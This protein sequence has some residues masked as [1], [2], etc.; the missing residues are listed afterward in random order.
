M[1]SGAKPG[2]RRGGRHAGVPN[3][4][5]T[6]ALERERIEQQLAAPVSAET[7]AK[8]EVL[9]PPGTP[10]E[11]VA[12]RKLAKERLEDLLELFVGAAAYYQPAAL[13]G[14]TRPAVGQ[15]EDWEQFARW[16]KLAMDCAKEAAKYQSPTFRAIVVAPAPDANADSNRRMKFTLTIFEGGRSARDPDSIRDPDKLKAV[17]G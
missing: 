14:Q 9:A 6:E 10:T 13:G 2:E 11:V 1:P 12:H 4:A 7:V 15:K 5:T 3:K 16:G 17:N 8:A